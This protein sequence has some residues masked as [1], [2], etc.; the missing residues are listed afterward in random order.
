MVLARGSGLSEHS[1]SPTSPSA[2]ADGPCLYF[3]GEMRSAILP[4]P[5]TPPEVLW[6]RFRG[7]AWPEPVWLLTPTTYARC[8]RS[9]AK[10]IGEFIQG[11]YPQDK[12]QAV[13]T[14][15]QP[16]QAHG[17]AWLDPEAIS[18]ALAVQEASRGRQ[19]RL[20]PPP[21][22]PADVWDDRS[23]VYNGAV[24]RFTMGAAEGEQPSAI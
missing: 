11:T 5:G 13:L 3:N 2:N 16:L 14:R 19:G 15:W 4:V 20:P 21:T 12:L 1:E 6:C 10:L 7:E 9:V 24:G 22:P 18:S 17:E 23:V 8:L